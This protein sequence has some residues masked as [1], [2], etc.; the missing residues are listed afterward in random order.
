MGS[1]VNLSL[2]NPENDKYV[3]DD[4]DLDGEG[5]EKQSGDKEVV[6]EK[7]MMKEKEDAEGTTEK[8]RHAADDDDVNDDD[9]LDGKMERELLLKMAS[10][11]NHAA[12]S[13]KRRWSFT[14][15][16]VVVA[17]ATL[18]LINVRWC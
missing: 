9:E 1:L 6:R 3:D 16:V 18:T 14:T 10:P 5:K 2:N 15:I 7:E 11:T 12:H 17:V 13:L 8:A 4:D